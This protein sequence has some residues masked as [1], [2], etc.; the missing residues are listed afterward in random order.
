MVS[1]SVAVPTDLLTNHA[2]IQ[3]DEGD[4]DHFSAPRPPGAMPQGRLTILL[5]SR[6]IVSKIEA[7]GRLGR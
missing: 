5:Y 7:R 4:P 6:M 1:P 2:H 3:S